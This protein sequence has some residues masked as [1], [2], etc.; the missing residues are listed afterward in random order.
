MFREFSAIFWI[1]FL[2][3][4]ARILVVPNSGWYTQYGNLENNTFVKG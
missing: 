4:E 1:L 3:A 2:I